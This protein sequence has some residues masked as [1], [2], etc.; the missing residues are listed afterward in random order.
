[1]IVIDCPAIIAIQF[2][3]ESA[4]SVLDSLASDA[5][6]LMSV[7]SHV[8]TGAVVAGRRVRDCENAI[9]YLEIV[10]SESEIELTLIDN[11]QTRIVLAARM[12]FWRSRRPSQIE[13][14]RRVLLRNR[15]VAA[16]TDAF[17]GH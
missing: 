12:R 4:P 6:R 14:W 10:I 1:M 13:L 15:Q 5:D 2:N 17:R 9:E 8:E 11:A 7:A 3:D 16:C